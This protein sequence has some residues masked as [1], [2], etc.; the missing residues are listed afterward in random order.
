MPTPSVHVHVSQLY[1]IC[2]N[3]TPWLRFLGDWNGVVRCCGTPAC[4]SCIN[5]C[6]LAGQACSSN[7][8]RLTAEDSHLLTVGDDCT[9]LGWHLKL[10]SQSRHFS[11][12]ALWQE[13][14]QYMM[15]FCKVS[16]HASQ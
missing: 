1:S 7:A 11:C 13:Y 5:N 2:R 3:T 4:A 8:N 16:A 10:H 12:K 6:T 9:G 15:Q 14:D